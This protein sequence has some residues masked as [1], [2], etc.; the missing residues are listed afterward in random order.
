MNKYAKIKI[1]IILE[2]LNL[3]YN[4]LERKINYE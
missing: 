4:I 3:R 1:Q 2:M